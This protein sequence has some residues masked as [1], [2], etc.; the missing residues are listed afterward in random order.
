MKKENLI[1]GEDFEI[2][3]DGKIIMTANYLKK[4]GHCCHS[5]CTNC[6]YDF[7]GTSKIDPH[8][9]QEFIDPW[10]TVPS[11]QIEFPFDDIE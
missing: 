6:P 9:P 2:S 11:E 5:A 7:Q 4:R 1:N 8:T 10:S 3:P